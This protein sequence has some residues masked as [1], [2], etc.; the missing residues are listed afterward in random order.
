MFRLR[1]DFFL[2]AAAVASGGG[3]RLAAQDDSPSSLDFPP[4]EASRA[5][6]APDSGPVGELPRPAPR[7][8]AAPGEGESGSAASLV[9]TPAPWMAGGEAC[10]SCG[11]GEATY[12]WNRCG[13]DSQLFPWT[14]GPGN[15]DSWCVG[16]HWGVQ[17]DGLILRRSSADLASLTGA[18]G[19]APELVDQFDYAP[20]ARIAAT[21]Y[22]AAGYGLQIVYEGVNEYHASALFPLVDATR[23]FRYESSF[24]SI[25]VNFLPRMPTLWKAFGGFRYL[26]VDEDFVDLTTVDKPLPLPADPPAAPAAFLDTSRSYLVE[27]R[28]LGFQLGVLRDGWQLNRWLALEG[29]CSAGVFVNDFK[30]EVI[31]DDVAT[32]I[33]GDDLATPGQNEFSQTVTVTRQT[34]VRNFS[35]LA[36]AGEA[37]ITLVARLNRCFAVRAGYQALV[38]D[39]VGLGIDAFFAPGLDSSSLF[40]HGLQAGLEYRR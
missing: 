12:P 1:I 21:G 7:N 40:Y 11:G 39:G 38:T 26:E 10:G 20:G 8:A 31:A 17:V 28:M 15:C 36:M 9:P 29:F 30:Q 13:C 14:P 18:A 27:N 6:T 16:P 19:V 37:G 22:N 23:D 24:N 35:D 33:G 32:V 5:W 25:E 3:V 34:T 2:M 4:L